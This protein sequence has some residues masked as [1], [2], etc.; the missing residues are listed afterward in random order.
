[1]RF[2]P[3]K[4]SLVALALFAGASQAYAAGTTDP[5]TMVVAQATESK[6]V[7]AVRK[8]LAGGKNVANMDAQRLQQPFAA[9]AALGQSCRL[10]E[11]G[12]GCRDQPR[13]RRRGREISHIFLDRS[14]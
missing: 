12:A 3:L 13:Q 4:A 2:S 11:A 5:G 7:E 10:L 8:F 1:M 14:S 6:R 9:I